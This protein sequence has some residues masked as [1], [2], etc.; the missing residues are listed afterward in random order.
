M[1]HT[2]ARFSLNAIGMTA[3]AEQSDA[4]R[5]HLEKVERRLDAYVTGETYLNYLDL[6]GATPARIRA[7]YSPADWQRLLA[8]KERYD[9]ANVFRF[10]RNISSSIPTTHRK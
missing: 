10:N 5:A 7:A 6:D 1:A 3:T 9:P 2:T 4:V 8:L